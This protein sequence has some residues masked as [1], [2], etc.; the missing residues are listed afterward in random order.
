MYAELKF[1]LEQLF[2]YISFKIIQKISLTYSAV[3]G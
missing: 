2:V 3:C 1:G